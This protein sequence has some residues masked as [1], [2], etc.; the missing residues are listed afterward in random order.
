MSNSLGSFLEKGQYLA[1]VSKIYE[2]EN[3]LAAVT[4][5]PKP[6]KT[7]EWH[8]HESPM[9]SF[10]ID[11]VN[12]ENRASKQTE[13]TSGSINFYHSFERHQ[14]IYKVFPSKHF[15]L[16][17]DINFL[18]EYEVKEHQFATAI[19]K[20]EI[21][22]KLLFIKIL[23]EVLF[24]DNLT[25]EAIKVLLLDIIDSSTG[26]E[27]YR[28]FPEWAVR[29][30]ELLNDNWNK[31]LSLQELSNETGVHPVTISGGFRRYFSCT[32][33]DY[34]RKL[35]VEHA[36]PLIRNSNNQ[37]TEI[38]YMCGFADQSHFTRCFKKQTGLLPKDFQRL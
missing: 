14:N 36:I 11:G 12:I 27:G 8:A 31:Q 24:R 29:L 16:E 1:P 10:V 38:T 30:K 9:I 7:G 17:I 6:D 22:S 23:N 19:Q 35:K 37:L 13:R 25:K 26:S 18:E 33:G 34:M 32:Y 3:L 21:V 15:S 5:Y 28:E 2:M 4:E 20:N